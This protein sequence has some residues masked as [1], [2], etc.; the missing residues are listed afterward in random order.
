MAFL[1]RVVF[2][3]FCCYASGCGLNQRLDARRLHDY[4]V[5]SF[6]SSN[7]KLDGLR[8][9]MFSS[10]RQGYFIFS[11]SQP[12]FFK[13][14]RALS[15]EHLSSG[16]SLADQCYYYRDRLRQATPSWDWV[17][18]EDWP[19]GVWIY[20]AVPPLPPLPGNQCSS[21]MVLIYDR[22]AGVACAILELG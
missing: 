22:S 11:I 18:R 15:L 21:F 3:L 17:G 8:E 6:A 9:G 16:E 19:E 2:S 4:F 10:S 13:L 14:E 20:Q 12:E 5:G 7:I 1:L